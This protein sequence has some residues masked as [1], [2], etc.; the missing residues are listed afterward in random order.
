MYNYKRHKKEAYLTLHNTELLLNAVKVKSLERG[1]V[2]E[3]RDAGSGQS[4]TI[5]REMYDEL[6]AGLPPIFKAA[7]LKPSV[8][9]D[10]RK[11]EYVNSL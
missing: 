4:V 11:Q 5:L 8:W 9:W 6:W 2:V 3:L 10:G 1:Q 7:W